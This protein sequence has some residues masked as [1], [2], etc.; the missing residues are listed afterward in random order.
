M[1]H[2]EARAGGVARYGEV[3]GKSRLVGDL[4]ELDLIR[5]V[6]TLGGE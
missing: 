1:L 4:E 5:E 6:S 2:R 3:V